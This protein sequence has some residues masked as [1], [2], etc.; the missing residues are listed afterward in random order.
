MTIHNSIGPIKNDNKQL[1]RGHQTIA[2]TLSSESVK[3]LLYTIWIIYLY[4]RCSQFQNVNVN[5]CTLALASKAMY[6]L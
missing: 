1:K 6:T 5:L 2:Q 4:P 3:L